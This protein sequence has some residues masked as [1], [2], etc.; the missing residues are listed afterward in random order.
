M[1]PFDLK[2][3]MLMSIMRGANRIIKP[4]AELFVKARF[5]TAMLL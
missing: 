2:W 5:L 3:I 1:V 4:N